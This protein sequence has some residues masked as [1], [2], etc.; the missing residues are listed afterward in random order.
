MNETDDLVTNL[1]ETQSSVRD[2]GGEIRDTIADTG[3]T[4]QEQIAALVV[5][6]KLVS[7]WDEG[8]LDL[9]VEALSDD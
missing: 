2:L 4:R 7:D 9:A 5:A 1:V 3:Y 6:I 8:L